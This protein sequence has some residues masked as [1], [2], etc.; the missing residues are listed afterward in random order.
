MDTLPMTWRQKYPWVRF[1]N[2]LCSGKK[3]KGCII[4]F[5]NIIISVNGKSLIIITKQGRVIHKAFLT[6]LLLHAMVFYSSVQ[7]YLLLHLVLWTLY[8]TSRSFKVDLQK[9]FIKYIKTTKERE[10]YFWLELLVCLTWHNNI[11]R[12]SKVD[13][14][15][16]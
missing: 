13:K 14:N 5:T 1:I 4:I 2:I 3:I 12:K 11:Q 8:V 6:S 9:W 10:V 15:I 16:Y 7:Y